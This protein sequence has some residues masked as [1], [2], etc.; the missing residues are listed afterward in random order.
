MKKL[1]VAI[2]GAGPNGIFA[3]STLKE[4]YPLF[5]IGCFEKGDRL[6]NLVNIPEVRW[7]SKMRELMLGLSADKFIDPEYIPLTSELLG[8]YRKYILEKQI[9]ISEGH[10]LI[11]LDYPDSEGCYRLQF[12]NGK[13]VKSTYI[14][15]STGIF[16]NKKK[17]SI[18]SDLVIYDF[19]FYIG[20]KI[21]LVG[22]GN[23]AVDFVIYN[24]ESNKITWL[25][26][27]AAINQMDPVTR[28]SFD[29]AVDLFGHNLTIVYNSQIISIKENIVDYGQTRERF[30]NVTALIGFDS[31]NSLFEKIGLEY[32]GDCLML[33]NDYQTSLPNVYAIGSISARWNNKSGKSEPTFIHNG[34]PNV[35]NKVIESI[36]KKM[37]QGISIGIVTDA[38]K[39]NYKKFKLKSLWKKLGI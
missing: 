9:I 1:D 28:S 30:D 10:E 35:L 25:V 24:L 26:R 3:Y 15:L 34:N 2:I 13:T 5:S 12:A 4:K 36:N 37:L 19:N 22:A 16:T 38:P 32:E 14:L 33:D 18:S 31:K 39:I 8:Y 17:L 23:S 7:H 21:C 29:R 20:K 27:G 11:R 6:F